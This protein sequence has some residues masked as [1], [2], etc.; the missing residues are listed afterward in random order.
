MEI[1]FLV[2]PT[3][4]NS[5]KTSVDRVYGCN[6]G[7]DY[8]PA[9]HLLILATIA[10][11][12][13]HCV[14]F[15]DCP[16]ERYNLSKFIDYLNKNNSFDAVVF[17]TVWLSQNEDLL[18]AEIIH[19]IF[20]NIRIIFTGPYP[21]WKPELFLKGSNYVVIRGEP[22]KS[23]TEILENGEW[24][25]NISHQ[26]RGLSF[27]KDSQTV[28]NISQELIDINT[29]PIPDRS[30]LKGNYTFNR[31]NE[32]PATAMCVSRG[33][34]YNC[35]YCAPHALDQAIELEYA[36]LHS[37]KPPL[38]LRTEEKVISEFEEIA[39]MGY[40]GVEVC[41][42]QF[43]WDKTRTIK[44]CNAIQHLQLSWICYA[45]ADHLLDKEMLKSMRRAGCQLIYIGTESF[46]QAILD[47]IN[48]EMS[49]VNIYKAIKLLRECSIEPEVSILLGASALESDETIVHSIQAA[50]RLKTNFIHYS[51]ASPL[52][53]T[54]LY[55]IAKE[56]GWI[57]TREFT[58][59]DNI[60]D[61]L[62]DLPYIKAER[63]K[64]II[65]ACYVRQYFSLRFIA[66]QII[67]PYFFKRFVLKLKMLNRL[68]RYLA[69]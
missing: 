21:T 36:S 4:L 1:L 61:A 18:A 10:E 12:S 34:S 46:N 3:E 26:I 43:V 37:K 53:N 44:I 50:R 9:I 65:R 57:K 63:L 28:N 35:A 59:I 38:R 2:P 11:Q 41:D 25:E 67:S 31:I 29:I 66:Q 62:L 49:V 16:A 48:K 8:K 45:R 32:Y 20:K 56:K 42:N 6:Y 19:G 5:K 64:K 69:F 30:L 60:R 13:G 51:I 54:Y 17:F 58:P 23:F 7:F 52:P 39:L 27:Y 24:K 14:K 55:K 40:K 47:D 68:V 22:E 15:L 33:C